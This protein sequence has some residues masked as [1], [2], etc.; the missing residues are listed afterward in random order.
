MSALLFS[1]SCRRGLHFWLRSAIMLALLS[2]LI[3]I[4]VRL[5]QS[6]AFAANSTYDCTTNPRWVIGHCYGIN[7]WVGGTWG[8]QT[9]IFVRQ[10]TCTNCNT[11]NSYHLNEEMWLIDNTSG[12]VIE[13]GYGARDQKNGATYY[14]WSNTPPGQPQQRNDIGAVPSGDYNNFS[15]FK[16]TRNNQAAD[17]VVV[18]IATQTNSRYFGVVATNSMGGGYGTP[19]AYLGNKI[20]IGTELVGNNNGGPM[21]QSSNGDISYVQSQWQYNNGTY[22][23]QTS[24]GTVYQDNPPISA[25]WSDPPSPPSNSGTFVTN[26]GC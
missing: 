9:Y 16:L 20:Q 19:S 10:L 21:F 5:D 7:Q 14:F 1:G 8:S 22:N 26:C 11:T 15:K 2:L 6:K 3:P 18:Q 13:V 25:V 4:S 12:G 17:Q 24:V 23:Q